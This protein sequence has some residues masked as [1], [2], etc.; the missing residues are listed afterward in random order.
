MS[1]FL[2]YFRRRKDPKATVASLRQQLQKIEEKEEHLRKKMDAE[3]KIARNNTAIDKSGMSCVA[4]SICTQLCT[5]VAL[6]SSRKGRKR[7]GQAPEMAFTTRVSNQR[8]RKCEYECGDVESDEKG[9]RCVDSST[10]QYV[11][12][13]TTP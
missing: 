3:L 2:S 11:G 13:A 1:G 4:S 6:N 9:V 8:S 7:A 5:L 12:Y 10:W